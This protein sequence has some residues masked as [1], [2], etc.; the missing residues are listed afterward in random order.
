VKPE[1]AA[2]SKQKYLDKARALLNK[3]AG[4][5]KETGLEKDQLFG[6][7]CFFSGIGK[8][9]ITA[10]AKYIEIPA[11][12]IPDSLSDWM[13]TT[14][15]VYADRVKRF[16]GVCRQMNQNWLNTKV[17]K[18]WLDSLA[19]KK[20]RRL[21]LVSLID[22]MRSIPGVDMESVEA[23]LK[24]P[25]MR[26]SEN[27]PVKNVSDDERAAFLKALDSVFIQPPAK[28]ALYMVC[29]GL[30]FGF[31]YENTVGNTLKSPLLSPKTREYIESKNIDKSEP[32]ACKATIQKHFAT[33]KKAANLPKDMRVA[34]FEK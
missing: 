19:S 33:F 21:S 3:R 11:D 2:T 6:H 27:R 23:V 9:K 31:I 24:G 8:Y 20:T 5:I 26:L 25:D 32:A 16:F 1:I 29:D 13:E 28:A 7:L 30:N 22:F 15:P 34:W 17:Q 18:A 14:N 12:A 10:P 4:E